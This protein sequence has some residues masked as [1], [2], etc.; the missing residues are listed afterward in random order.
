LSLL[1]KRKDKSETSDKRK[2]RREFRLDKIIE[3]TQLMIAKAARWKWLAAV[4]GVALLFYLAFTAKG[5][6]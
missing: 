3:K 1:N 4:I 5:C 6:F 2:D